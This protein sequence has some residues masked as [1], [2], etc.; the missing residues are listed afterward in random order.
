[1]LRWKKIEVNARAPSEGQAQLD[2]MAV[3]TA[4]L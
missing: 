4:M 1:M 3:E 2:R